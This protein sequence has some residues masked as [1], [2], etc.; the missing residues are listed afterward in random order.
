MNTT[1]PPPP[2][3]VGFVGLGMMGAPIAGRLAAAGVPLVVHNRTRGKADPLIA[4]GATWAETPRA[5][6]RAAAGHVVFTMLTDARAV[7]A[8]L[9][10]RTGVAAGAAAGTLV[11]DLSTIAPEES[12]RFA[13]RL[14]TRGLRYV[15]APVGGSVDA[16]E[17]GE[18]LVYAGGE[19]EDVDRARPYLE[20]FARRT[21]RLGP[22]GA[23]TSMKLVNNLVTIAGFAVTAEALALAEGLGLPRERT[24]ELLLAGG[25]RSRMLEAKRESLERRSY[26]PRFKLSLAA[27]DLRLAERS[28]R[29][30]GVGYRL[31]R[32]A[33][34][35]A[36]EGIRAGL[37]EKD[38]SSLLEAALARGRPAAT[39][40]APVAAPGPEADGSPGGD[41]RV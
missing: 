4:Q 38:F 14:R 39:P 6:G 7:R 8:T 2:G 16:A 18:L 13:E 25:A 29:E 22:V 21:E 12:R 34:R 10:G 23:G 5:V 26:P 9:F 30:S 37:S 20:R 17:T 11:V 19:E 31:A 15:D 40:R 1:N 24:V 3:P 41:E 28:A 35:L 27:K 33:R 36:D 32:E